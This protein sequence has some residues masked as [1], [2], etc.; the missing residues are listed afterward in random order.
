MRI[1][2]ANTCVGKKVALAK[3]HH[4]RKREQSV[5]SEELRVVYLKRYNRSGKVYTEEYQ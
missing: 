2:D 3:A 4:D 5:G 1:A